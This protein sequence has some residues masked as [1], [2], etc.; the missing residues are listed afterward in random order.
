MSDG[1]LDANALVPL[2]QQPTHQIPAF[3]SVFI[4]DGEVALAALREGCAPSIGIVCVNVKIPPSPAGLSLPQA[5]ARHLEDDHP[6]AERVEKVGLSLDPTDSGAE[7][8]TYTLDV[9]VLLWWAVHRVKYRLIGGIVGAYPQIRSTAKIDEFNRRFVSEPSAL[10]EQDVVGLDVAVHD[11]RVMHRFHRLEELLREGTNSFGLVAYAHRAREAAA[12]ATK[13]ALE[14]AAAASTEDNVESGTSLIFPHEV[15]VRAGDAEERRDALCG[16][17]SAIERRLG[18]EKLFP[19][20]RHLALLQDDA[21]ALV[22]PFEHVPERPAAD[23]L[24]FRD[25]RHLDVNL[26][27]RA[28]RVCLLVVLC[29]DAKRARAADGAGDPSA[30][31]SRGRQ[32]SAGP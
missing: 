1:V 25:V 7:E 2:R 13:K 31:R 27:R 9:E 6:T 32:L 14:S 15:R 24:P 10:C 21:L 20:A 30:G 26:D 28:V 22:F 19:G 3:P 23:L 8:R 17:K 29:G 4:Q 11:S 18:V 16:L 5:R 12:A